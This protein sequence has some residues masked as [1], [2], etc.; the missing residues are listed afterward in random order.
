MKKTVKGNN[1][2]FEITTRRAKSGNII[3]ETTSVEQADS[4][5]GILKEGFGD[6]TNIRRPSPTVPVFL[7]GIEDSVE[8]T[9]LREALEAFD[10][11]L[12]DIRNFVIKESKNELRTAVIRAPI[13]AG[14]ILI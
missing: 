11:E 5:A 1:L 8:E 9:E 4:L 12:K 2:T 7:V 10:S 13:R 14:R 6:T 3:L